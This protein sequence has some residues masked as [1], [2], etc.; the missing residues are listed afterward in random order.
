MQNFDASFGKAVPS[1]VTV[2]T[3]SGTNEF[4]GSAFDYWESNAS[5]AC[6]PFT[7]GPSQL[8]AASPLPGGLKNQFGSSAGGPIIKNKLFF[9]GDYQGTRQKVGIAAVQTVPTAALVSTCL[10]TTTASNG[11]AGFLL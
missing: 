5:L 7:Q 9:F 2:Q 6:C 8:T 11:T 10:G 4:R 3:K 1:I